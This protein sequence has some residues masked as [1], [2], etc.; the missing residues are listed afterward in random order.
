MKQGSLLNNHKG[1]EWGPYLWEALTVR[2]NPA[3][4]TRCFFFLPVRF[5]HVFS[6]HILPAKISRIHGFGTSTINFW[7]VVSN[8][9]YFHPK[10]LGKMNPFWRSYFSKGLVQPPTSHF[11]RVKSLL[12]SGHSCRFCWSIPQFQSFEP[13]SM[14][15]PAHWYIGYSGTSFLMEIAN[16]GNR[17]T[18]QWPKRSTLCWKFFG[19]WK[20]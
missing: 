16:R 13:L 9:F 1:V 8:M 18:E 5:P 4:K 15:H 12:V 6:L 7:V 3:P 10:T 17:S 20:W 2:K 14:S 11:S 19:G